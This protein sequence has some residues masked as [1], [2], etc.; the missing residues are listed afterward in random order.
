MEIVHE[1][2]EIE[3]GNLIPGTKG[4]KKNELE[5]HTGSKSET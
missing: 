2:Y 5:R 1:K 4:E 3:S